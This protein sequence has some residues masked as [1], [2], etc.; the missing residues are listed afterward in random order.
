MSYN[1]FNADRLTAMSLN[2]TSIGVNNIPLNEIKFGCPTKEHLKM[3]QR[4]LEKKDAIAN[5]LDDMGV[6]AILL[7]EHPPANDSFAMKEELEL[8]KNH[9]MNISAQDTCFGLAAEI[10]VALVFKE[11]VLKSFGINLPE[12]VLVGIGTQTEP[13]VM[14]LKNFFNRPRPQQLGMYVGHPIYPVVQTDSN[15]ASYPSGHS[16]MAFNIARAVAEAY[17]ETAEEVLN[18]AIEIANSRVNLGL[19]YPS[20]NAFSRLLSDIL[21]KNNLVKNPLLTSNK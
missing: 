19:H 10:S 13:F 5:C 2:P 21:W 1:I 8:L 18:L 15:T 20:D 14:F 6:L 3:I 16:L 9:S 17:P 11:F 12:T 4:V 7:A